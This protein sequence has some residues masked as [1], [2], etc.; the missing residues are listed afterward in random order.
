MNPTLTSISSPWEW[1]SD[2]LSGLEMT[3]AFWNGPEGN[4]WAAVELTAVV[5]VFLGMM[6]LA[7]RKRR[8]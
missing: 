3:D 6:V 4:L 8:R 1:P 7:I 2:W 5:G